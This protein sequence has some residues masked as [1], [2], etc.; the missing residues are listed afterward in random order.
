M[1]RLQMTE[2]ETEMNLILPN[3]SSPKARFRRR[4]L[5]G[6]S[7]FTLI[8]LLV[9]IAIIAI[10][11][12]MLLPALSHAK[13][14]AQAIAC[15]NNNKQLGLGFL[16]YAGDAQSVLP[17]TWSWCPGSLDYNAGNTDNT[18]TAKMLS[19]EVGPY[20]KNPGVFKC[21]ADRS[22]GV[23]AGVSVPRCRSISMSQMIRHQIPDAGNGH[24]TSPP[25]RVYGKESD[26]LLP[27]PVN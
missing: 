25:W 12:A 22:V 8:E 26:M 10:L 2:I 13:V 6:A 21:P 15:L 17:S 5:S 14:K 3:Q 20:V 27:A 24:S 11:A 16:M 9:V 18:N 4:P 23:F 7:G 19:G 1:I